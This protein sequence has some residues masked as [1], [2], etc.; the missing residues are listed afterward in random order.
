[1]SYLHRFRETAPPNVPSASRLLHLDSR[2]SPPSEDLRGRPAYNF[3]HLTSPASR[4]TLRITY[5]GFPEATI[6]ALP[7]VSWPRWDE[8]ATRQQRIKRSGEDLRCPT[9][10]PPICEGGPKWLDGLNS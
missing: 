8:G 4:S 7:E 3:R 6:R 5:R 10:A 9:S 2:R 1:M